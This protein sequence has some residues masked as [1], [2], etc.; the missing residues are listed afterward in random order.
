MLSTQFRLCVNQRLTVP[1]A[2]ACEAHENGGMSRTPGIAQIIVGTGDLRDTRAIRRIVFIT[3]QGVAE[4]EEMAA[5][6]EEAL[7]Q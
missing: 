1:I 2:A 6:I 5:A 4:A 3:E 7:G